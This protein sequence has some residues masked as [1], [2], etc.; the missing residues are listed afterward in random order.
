M[1]IPPILIA[2][3]LCDRLPSSVRTQVLEDRAFI[4]QYGRMTKTIITIGGIFS[5]DQIELI[6][7]ARRLLAG[8]GDQT[9]KDTSGR[10]VSLALGQDVVSLKGVGEKDQELSVVLPDLVVLSPS[11][12]QRTRAI[13]RMID[14]FGPAA[15]DFSALMIA[16]ENRD[17]TDNEFADLIDERINGFACHKAKIE[18]A[19]QTDQIQ[20]ADIV[21]DSLHYYEHFCGPAPSLILPEEYIKVTLPAHRQQLLRR[22][23]VEGLEIC[24]L[25]ALR[26]D[27]MPAAWTSHVSDDDMWQAL[28]SIDTRANP[29]TALGVLDIAITR[30]H[31]SRYLSLASQTMN[32]LGENQLLRPDGMDSYEILPL[33]AQLTLDRINVLEGG[34][35]Y[36][37][38]WKRLCAWMHASLLAQSTL[39]ISIKPE[40]LSEWVNNNRDMAGTYA[41]IV[42]LR[43]EPMYRAG[44]FSQAYL[45]QEVIG[46]LV[47]LRARHRAAGSIVPNSDVIDAAMAKLDKE[48]SPLGWAMPGP[49]DGHIRPADR[50]NRKFSEVDIA[51]VL[52]E[53]SKD[54]SGAI[55]SKLAYFSQCFDLGE[56]VLAQACKAITT[57]S[58]D[59]EL[60]KGEERPARLFDIGLIAA[61]QRHKDLANSIATIAVNKAP[62]ATTDKA[63]V[64]LLHIIL[65][66]SAAIENE[67]EWSSWVSEQLATLAHS[68]PAG[69]ATK[70]LREHLAEIKTVL[71]ISSAIASSAESIAAAAN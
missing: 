9:L 39:H 53:L 30:Q 32:E 15:P 38:F 29:F 44:Q 7:A 26:D 16:A 59:H 1:G 41:Q 35:L 22:N 8:K 61:A 42:D 52:E 58:F 48:G 50:E 62:L 11:S 28:Q 24:L 60:V 47:V 51:H 36:Q 55:W 27:L 3:H 67:K 45:R 33:F 21:P 2:R 5:V 43:R 49:L 6:A 23:L 10:K 18:A 64:S 37:P 57:A 14:S 34:A 70:A 65:L 31:D 4:S 17:L 25:G 66:A 56:K 20:L 71:P 46:R 68:L 40:A 19:H 12:G 13:K 54:P 69:E 63:A